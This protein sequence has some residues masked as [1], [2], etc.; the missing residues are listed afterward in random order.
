MRSESWTFIWQPKVSIR[1]LRAMCVYRAFSCTSC[2]LGWLEA[3]AYSAFR[4]S[5][6]ACRDFRFRLSPFAFR[7]SRG[8]LPRG[9][10]AHREH[11]SRRSADRVGDFS[12]PEHSGEFFNP[13]SIVQACD[14]RA[15][16]PIFDT[17]L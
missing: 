12:P 9:G 16:A 1:Y 13:R 2:D 5:A 14:R 4:V 10:A 8:A 17:L 3:I 15:G 11:F 6:P 7:P